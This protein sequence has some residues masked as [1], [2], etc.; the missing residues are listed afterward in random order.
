MRMINQ[1]CKKPRK[2]SAPMLTDQTV[3]Q[4]V[5]HMR[6]LQRPGPYVAAQPCCQTVKC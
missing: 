2:H 3:Y 5:Y 1:A 6:I 4:Q